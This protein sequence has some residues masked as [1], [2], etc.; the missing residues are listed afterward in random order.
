M[1]KSTE[2]RGLG[3]GE[4]QQ[5]GSRGMSIS[6][7]VS[8]RGWGKNPV[9]PPAHAGSRSRIYLPWIW[10]RYVPPKRRL[11][12]DLHSATSQK[13]TFFIV[14]AVKASNL[15]QLSFERK[16]PPVSIGQ[17]VGRAR[18]PVWTLWRREKFLLS[19]RIEPILTESGLYIEWIVREPKSIAIPVTSFIHSYVINEAL[20]TVN[21]KPHC[22]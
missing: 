14:T 7:R 20:S 12:Q 10:R 2:R 15:T 8:V 22:L 1:G 17:E 16:I 6:G 9:Q 21:A 19:P 11:T 5:A 4:G 3:S 18:E 13:T